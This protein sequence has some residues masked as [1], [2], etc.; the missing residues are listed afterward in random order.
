M[1]SALSPTR[2]G[3]SSSTSSVRGPGRQA[4]SPACSSSAAR[5]RPNTWPFSREAGLVREERHGRN[6]LYHLHADALEEIGG[7]V[8]HFEHYWNRRLDAL[9]ELLDEEKPS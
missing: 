6:R 1:C 4:N 3:A 2:Q 8:K 9:A 5:Q 7:W